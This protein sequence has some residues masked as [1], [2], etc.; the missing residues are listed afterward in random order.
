MGILKK[1]KKAIRRKVGLELEYKVNV[2]CPGKVFLGTDYGGWCICPE[3]ITSASVLY[4]LG[5][6]E[7]I[8]F[9]SAM[10]EKYALQVFAFDP[11]PRSIAWV[12]GQDLPENFCFNDF[13]IASC[14]GTAMF[15]PHPNPKHVSHTVLTRRKCG[16]QGIEVQFRKLKTAMDMLGHTKIDILKMDIEGSEY[17]VIDDLLTSGIEVGQPLVEFHHEKFKNIGVSHTKKSIEKLRKSGYRIF[18]TSP[19]QREFSFMRA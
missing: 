8:S 13:G 14:N 2:D 12:K 9:D 17:E 19:R 11:T 18:Y 16:G 3:K 6:G 5:V 4:S 1:I 15:Y 10:I 7:D